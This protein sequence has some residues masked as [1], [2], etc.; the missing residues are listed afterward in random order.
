MTPSQSS[1]LLGSGPARSRCVR[2]APPTLL[3]RVQL[4]RVQLVP[5]Q[6]HLDEGDGSQFLTELLQND[7]GS[8]QRQVV[9][10]EDTPTQGHQE[11]TSSASQKQQFTYLEP[12]EPFMVLVQFKAE[13]EGYLVSALR[14][15]R[16]LLV[17]S[18]R[19]GSSETSW[20]LSISSPIT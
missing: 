12:T 4:V 19:P 18:R 16:C 11:V 20:I 17:S 6:R 15:S 1:S 3:V 13:P 9:Q 5:V 7:D 8:E 2:P 14:P 10:S